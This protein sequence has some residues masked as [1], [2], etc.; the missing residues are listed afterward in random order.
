MPVCCSNK[1]IKRT[2]ARACPHRV[3][4]LLHGCVGAMLHHAHKLHP[5]LVILGTSTIQVCLR[6]S[7]RDLRSEAR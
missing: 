7:L 4:I 1:G 3:C 5:P 2:C 6:K